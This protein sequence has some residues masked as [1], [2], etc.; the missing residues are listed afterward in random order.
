MLATDR[1]ALLCDLAEVYHIFDFHALPVL[2]LA[3]LSVG[4][5]DDS[6]IKMKMAGINYIP[7]VV[8]LA[9]ISDNLAALRYS[10]TAKKGDP[11]PKLFGELMTKQ[12]ERKPARKT[13]AYNK[14]LAGIMADVQKRIE[15]KGGEGDG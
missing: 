15:Q 11:K 9:S 1:D 10:L 3:A 5:R 7:P 6:R 2:T 13:E 4:L 8:I 14:T 12:I